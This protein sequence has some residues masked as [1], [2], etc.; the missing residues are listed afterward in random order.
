MVPYT[1]KLAQKQLPGQK[2]PAQIPT[3]DQFREKERAPKPARHSRKKIEFAVE[4]DE[5]ERFETNHVSET[6]N[7]RFT[8]T[9]ENRHQFDQDADSF[10]DQE[11]I[12]E[13]EPTNG[14]LNSSN[15]MG[16][17]LDQSD[18]F[19]ATQRFENLPRK[20]HL[21]DEK[22]LDKVALFK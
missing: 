19:N 7:G 9:G 4:A 13:E 17:K 8:N 16:Y 12:E 20:S 2:E 6:L 3:F 1:S 5:E 18:R 14:G 21:E 22:R 11:V 15:N 10:E